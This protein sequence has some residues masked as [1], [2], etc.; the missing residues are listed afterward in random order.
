[1]RAIAIVPRMPADLVSLS[2]RM[3]T[4]PR[5]AMAMASWGEQQ[6]S[7]AMIGTDTLRAIS[8]MPP[9]SHFGTGCSTKSRR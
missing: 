3:L 8:A 7:S 5:R 4:P 2:A 6:D 1:M 9:R